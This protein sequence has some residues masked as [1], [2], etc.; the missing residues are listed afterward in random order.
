[1]FDLT[2]ALNQKILDEVE[3]LTYQGWRIIWTGMGLTPDAIWKGSWIAIEAV[4]HNQKRSYVAYVAPIQAEPKVF[5]YTLKDS[6]SHI[7]FPV[8]ASSEEIVDA[9]KAARALLMQVVVGF[10][11]ADLND[12]DQWATSTQQWRQWT[13]QQT[14]GLGKAI[15]SP[16]IGST[17]VLNPFTNTTGPY[18]GV[19][20]G[21]YASLQNAQNQTTQSAP[22]NAAPDLYLYDDHGGELP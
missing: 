21:N 6:I 14:A 20:L 15:S 19:G 11:E 17:Q 7:G 5:R 4:D 16:P 22:P 13:Q 1:M 8:T 9:V 2:L 10:R 3:D 12:W 18:F